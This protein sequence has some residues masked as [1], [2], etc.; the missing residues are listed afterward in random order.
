MKWA[1]VG[2]GSKRTVPMS[3][4]PTRGRRPTA[5]QF[6]ASPAL[7]A[8]ER[9]FRDLASA[10]RPNGTDPRTLA[11]SML[12][13]ATFGPPKQA[14][15]KSRS[16]VHSGG[17][18]GRRAGRLRFAGDHG[19]RGD[20]QIRDR[21]GILQCR[22]YDL[23]RV[24]DAGLT[25]SSFA[26]MIPF[27]RYAAFVAGLCSLRFCAR[28]TFDHAE[29]VRFLENEPLFAVDQPTCRTARGRRL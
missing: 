23:G 26:T 6:R 3:A 17:R 13:S 29:N 9:E 18:H 5:H 24:D 2:L 21:R 25:M 14:R 4:A 28:L 12:R 27:L 15:D 1:S 11:I 8:A 19:L 16:I 10:W 7:I 20:D 22:A